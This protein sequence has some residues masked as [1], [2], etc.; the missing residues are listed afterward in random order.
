[1]TN[2]LEGQRKHMNIG[3]GKRRGVYV[4]SEKRKK[5]KGER[6]E[7]EERVEMRSESRGKTQDPGLVSCFLG[8]LWLL[9]VPFCEVIFHFRQISKHE[10]M[11]MTKTNFSSTQ[12]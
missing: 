5:W 6:H 8:V 1:M 10:I 2:R 7:A 3:R 11:K 9:F 12:Y 4:R